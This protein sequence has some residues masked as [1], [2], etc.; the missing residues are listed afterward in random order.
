MPMRVHMVFGDTSI[1]VPCGDGKLTVAE[2]V[3]KGVVKFKKFIATKVCLSISGCFCGGFR[4]HLHKAGVY[5][6]GI[7]MA[8]LG[9]CTHTIV[10]ACLSN[11][12]APCNLNPIVS[13]SLTSKHFCNY[14]HRKSVHKS[15]WY[16]LVYMY[17]I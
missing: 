5:L 1:L 12:T 8:W 17:L 15:A 14:F 7:L 10:L 11:N 9:R 16:Q 6:W 13:T 3:E 4:D 2:L